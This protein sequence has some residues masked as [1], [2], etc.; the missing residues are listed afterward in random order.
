MDFCLFPSKVTAAFGFT[1]ISI[2][3]CLIQIK[4]KEADFWYDY[5]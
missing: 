5:L 3:L 1:H 4:T 2:T